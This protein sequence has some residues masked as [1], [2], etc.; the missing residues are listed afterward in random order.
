MENLNNEFIISFTSQKFFDDALWEIED[1]DIKIIKKTIKVNG[2][3]VYNINVKNN[4]NK[5]SVLI[6]LDKNFSKLTAFCPCKDCSVTGSC[7]H[8]ALGLMEIR[9]ELESESN[10]LK[11]SQTDVY[12]L[13]LLKSIYTIKNQHD[14]I[15]LY[16]EVK[17]N[18]DLSIGIGLRAGFVGKK[19]Y[20]IKNINSFLND[21]TNNNMIVLAKGF[22]SHNY[23][24]EKMSISFLNY[25]KVLSNKY[26]NL[27][28]T[29]I[30]YSEFNELLSTVVNS[31][32]FFQKDVYLVKNHLDD[33]VLDVV[34]ENEDLLIKIRKATYYNQ[35]GTNVVLNIYNKAFYHLN[36]NQ[37][38]KIKLINTFV[39]EEKE[40]RISS[41]EK[42]NFFNEVLPNIYNE[43]DVKLDHKLDLNIVDEALEITLY[44]Y[45]EDKIIHIN[46]EFKYGEYV[47]DNL[48]EGILLK[49]NHLKEKQVI[50]FLIDSGYVYD[51]YK[52]NFI[53]EA[54]RN[55]FNF[56][57][58]NIF[59]LKHEYTTHLDEKLKNAIL[60]YDSNQISIEIEQEEAMDYFKFD[61]DLN[62]IELDEVSD[63]L[64]SYE[65]KKDFHRLT[66]DMFIKLNDDKLYLQLLFIKEV[67]GDTT[68]TLNTFRVPKYKAILIKERANGLFDHISY[69]S[70][71]MDYVDSIMLIPRLDKKVLKDSHY[72]LREYQKTGIEWLCN[73]YDANLGALLADEMGLGKTIQVISFLKI[74]KI[75]NALIV[76]PK[77]LLYN[78][79]NEFK[80]FNPDQKV[81]L[82]VGDLK[83][84]KKILKNANDNEIIITSYSS[85]INDFDLYSSK[86]YDCLII[87]E[88]Q[89]IKNSTTKTTRVI[90]QINSNF[91][92]ALTGTPI[93]NNL[94]ELWSIF[95]YIIPGYLNDSRVFSSTYINA[96]QKDK[97]H[98]KK[99]IAPFIMR[100]LKKD[101]LLDLP[102]KIIS[103]V[104]CEMNPVQKQ[105]YSQYVLKYKDDN[106]NYF[107]KNIMEALTAITRLRQLSIDPDLFLDDYMETSG[108]IEVFM[109]L[110]DEICESNQKVIVFS[111]YTKM[112]KKLSSKLDEKNISFYYLDGETKAKNRMMDVE[113]FN[114]NKIP[115]Y[116]ISLKAGGVG[117]NL[118]SAS[119]V[120][121]VD[122][123]WNP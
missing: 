83:S 22:E 95:D 5:L 112:L 11:I 25:L 39:T 1:V 42:N 99:I 111:Q 113:K 37:L 98:L 106:K 109:E 87:D 70:E 49:R 60:K 89:Y 27:N 31:E 80:K 122:P 71:F 10:E 28:T 12:K 54:D 105:L 50:D 108:K 77:A 64:R 75:T 45:L 92:I 29:M 100:R 33:I 9:R 2:S 35:I 18:I 86:T 47:V 73:L 76:V 81:K 62:G 59:H 15:K 3:F 57:T 7:K 78:W 41:D 121:I 90:K 119:N 32:V 38:Q 84:R 120:I 85:M 44:C 114:K 74:K 63:I 118:T 19:N 55:Q 67:I 102:A 116:L 43:F 82:V 69:N 72:E 117:L 68:H 21:I 30:T 48:D 58:K 51:V 40:F 104:M 97:A 65:L 66:N 46:P 34:C 4:A 20:V 91:F 61:V 23:V 13:E 36:D 56:L 53:I 14:V 107:D 52:N 16:L 110:V 123:W 96:N 26:N 103:D 101:V 88:A 115:I 79:E 6:T 24:I 8:V 17:E 94:L 93:E